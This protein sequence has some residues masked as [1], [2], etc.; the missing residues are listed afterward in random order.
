RCQGLAR[1]GKSLDAGLTW[2]LDCPMKLYHT[3][4]LFCL[5]VGCGAPARDSVATPKKDNVALVKKT[6]SELMAIPEANLRDDTPLSQLS[7]PMDELDLVELVMELE[8]IRNVAI[9]DQLLVDAAG[10][11]GTNVLPQHLTIKKLA[12]ILDSA[13]SLPAQHSPPATAAAKPVVTLTTGAASKVRDAL[14]QSGKPMLRVAVKSGGSTGFMYDLQFAD[15]SDP[16][17]DIQYTDNGIGIVV[18][19]KS[20]L[21]LEGTVIDWETNAEGQ[22]GFKFN[23]PNAVESP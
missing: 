1:R 22:A 17:S 20:S 7:T 19:R 5:V 3:A 8:E 4:L 21:Y 10:T 11:D 6:V 15:K 14:Q 23:N 16:E 18:D 2:T 13:E 9:P 12:A